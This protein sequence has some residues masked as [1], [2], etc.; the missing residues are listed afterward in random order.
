MVFQAESRDKIVTAVVGIA[1]AIS[2][3]R[4]HAAAMNVRYRPACVEEHMEL[5]RRANDLYHS[6]RYLAAS[7]MREAAAHVAARCA[8]FHKFPSPGN[9]SDGIDLLAAGEAAHLGG[10]KIRAIALV[11][12]AK[13][14]LTAVFSKPI[15][16]MTRPYIEILLRRADDDLHGRWSEPIRS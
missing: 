2:C 14:L 12:R 9:G 4:P 6:R 1:L 10:D 8:P 7:K 5:A 11:M 13:V 15:S 16:D 3:V